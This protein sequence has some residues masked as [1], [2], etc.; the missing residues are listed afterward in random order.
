MSSVLDRSRSDA[1]AHRGEQ[2]AVVALRWRADD[3]S[4]TSWTVTADGPWGRVCGRGPDCFEAL[5]RVREQLE[6]AGWLLGVNGARRDTWPSGMGRATGGLVV[7]RLVPGA[8]PTRADLLD[9]FADAP[10]EMLATVAEQ[11]LFEHQ[12]TESLHP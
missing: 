9:T 11:T 8:R 6:S 7:C 10:R 2:Q 12:W 5:A 3:S 1:V 4:H